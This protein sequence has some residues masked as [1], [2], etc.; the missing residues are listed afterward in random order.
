MAEVAGLALGVLGIA[1]LFTSCIENFD[2]VMRAKDFGVDFDLLCTLVTIVAEDATGV[3]G[4]TLGLLPSSPELTR[5]VLYNGAIDREDIRPSIISS[6]CQLRDLLSKADVVTERYALIEG[7]SAS[8]HEYAQDVSQTPRGMLV[9]RDSFQKFKERI[10]KNQQQKSVWKVTRWSVHDYAQLEHLVDNIRKLLDGLES[11]TT[12]LGLLELQQRRLLEEVDSVSDAQSLSL[13]QDIGSSHSAPAAMK[14]ISETASI[15]LTTLSGDSQ[16]YYTAKTG[17]TGQ[18]GQTGDHR[19][20]LPFRQKDL[21][22]RASR[23]EEMADVD[24]P[25]LGRGKN[26]PVIQETAPRVVSKDGS[27]DTLEPI[28]QHQ[29]WMSALLAGRSDVQHM[30]VF[31]PDD[32]HYGEAI[33]SFKATDE[34]NYRKV[35][36]QLAVQA[37][38]GFRL[39]QRVFIE[40]RNIHRANIPFISAVPVG[41]DLDRILACIEGPPG[42]PY[43]G[44]TFW[45]TVRITES[46]PPAMRFHTRIYHPN[47]DHTGKVC[48]DYAGWWQAAMVLNK[49]PNGASLRRDLPWF[50]ERAT[51]HYSLGAL[52]VALC[53]LLASPNIE[54]PLVPEIAEKYVTD[55]GGYCE[56]ARLYTQRYAGPLRP[57]DKDLVFLDGSYAMEN[58]AHPDVSDIRPD[59]GTSTSSIE[60]KDIT[61]I[62]TTDDKYS[63]RWDYD[64][65]KGENW[66][67]GAHEGEEYPQEFMLNPISYPQLDYTYEQWVKESDGMASLMQ[68]ASGYNRLYM[69]T[70]QAINFESSE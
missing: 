22:P 31:S 70:D 6:L 55:Y 36:G 30:P 27:S 45:I 8:T 49:E 25:L 60:D 40:L 3:M 41:D 46:Q 56:A 21:W 15:R 1:G 4:E 59:E 66:F 52:L 14:A 61:P 34:Q 65:I 50:S 43:Q 53:G 5:Q 7:T 17:Q 35:S 39:A 42:T 28:P 20:I 10:R 47:I 32:I 19:L 54:D 58:S 2:I 57:A 24:V 23:K 12:A 62:K 18:T 29:R 26:D 48:A 64:E 37:H 44:G 11:I 9:F 38:T 63:G 16:S 33:R 68:E 13:L 51:N 69:Q 67:N